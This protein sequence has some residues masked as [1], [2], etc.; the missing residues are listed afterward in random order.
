MQRRQFLSRALLGL[1][2]A[3]AAAAGDGRRRPGARLPATP[4]AKIDKV[5]K[6]EDEWRKLLTPDAIP[7]AA[8]GGHRAPV[9]EPAQQRKAQGDVRVRRVRPAAVRV[10]DQV[11]QRHGMAELLPV[12]RRPRRDLG[13]ARASSTR[14]PSIT[15][16]AAAATTA[17]YSTTA[18]SRRACATATT[19]SRSSSSRP[20]RGRPAAGPRRRPRR[21]IA[22][23]G[24]PGDPL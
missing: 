16:R 3:A 12:H 17:T 14:A 21:V 22:P 13:R 9:H 8:P 19:A 6:T 18:R 4:T 10:E 11:R 7:R 20:D 24:A 15:A 5:V 23:G 1:A 2:G